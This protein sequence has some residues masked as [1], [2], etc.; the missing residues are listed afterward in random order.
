MGNQTSAPTPPATP[1]QNPVPS[2]PPPPPLPPPCDLTCQKQNQLTLLKQNMDAIDPE[3]NPEGYEQARIAYFTLLNGPG[4]LAQ[5]KNTIASQEVEPVL[6]SYQDQ[7]NALKGEQQSQTIFTNLATALKSQESGDEES[8][9]FL[10]KQLSA[11]KTKAEVSDRLNQLNAGTPYTPPQT[12][13]YISWA[14]DILIA[15]L[16]I[17]VVYKAYTRFV[18]KVSVSPNVPVLTST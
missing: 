17:F 13:Q 11:E 12:S 9:R 1:V 14:I 7:Y 16:G 8:N 6:K 4:W 2:P 3:Q 18:G 5:E 10:K 15:I